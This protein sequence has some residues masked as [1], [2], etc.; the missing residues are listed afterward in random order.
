MS[1]SSALTCFKPVGGGGECGGSI[2]QGAVPVQQPA[3]PIGPVPPYEV[4]AQ[5]T[6][7]RSDKATTYYVVLGTVDLAVV[8]VVG[9]PGGRGAGTGSVAC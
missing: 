9:R 1:L 3:E 6:S 2:T 4:I 8:G 5:R 7:D